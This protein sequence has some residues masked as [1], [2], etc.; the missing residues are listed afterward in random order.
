MGTMTIF[1]V[2]ESPPPEE[3]LTTAAM[4]I[5]IYS[6]VPVFVATLGEASLSAFPQLE[7]QEWLVAA[8]FSGAMLSGIS[9]A[10]LIGATFWASRQEQLAAKSKLIL[11]AAVLVALGLTLVIP[12]RVI[13]KKYYVWNATG[14]PDSLVLDITSGALSGGARAGELERERPEGMSEPHNKQMQQ[15]RSAPWSRWWRGPRC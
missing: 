7:S 6:C 10:P 15:T 11:W 14:E 4:R 3:V 2:P 12:S 5:A 8:A 1:H 9:L 13:N